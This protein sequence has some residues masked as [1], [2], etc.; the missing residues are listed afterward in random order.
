MSDM[1]P[2][3]TKPERTL[4]FIVPTLGDTAPQDEDTVQLMLFAAARLEQEIIEHP[5]RTVTAM[6]VTVE[7]QTSGWQDLALLFSRRALTHVTV[8]ELTEPGTP[9]LTIPCHKAAYDV[10]EFL[11]ARAFDEVHGLDRH[12]VLYYLTQGKRLGLYFLET[13]FAV[14]VV[15]GTIFRTE[16]EDALLDDVSALAEDLLERG[17]LERADAIYVHDT[18]AWRWYAGKIN[19]HSAVRIYDIAWP[20]G[21][22]APQ[23]SAPV[24]AGDIPAIVFYGTLG[25]DGGLPLFCDTIDRALPHL[26]GPVEIVCVGSPRPIGGSDAVSYIRLRSGAWRVP[27]RIERGLSVAEEVVRIA[28]QPAVVVCDT[29]RREGL[30]PRLIIDAG[31]PVLHITRLPGDEYPRIDCTYPALP[32]RI[33]AKLVEMLTTTR[34][35]EAQSSPRVMDLWRRHRPPLPDL[36]DLEPAQRLETDSDA[37]PKVSVIVTH[38]SRPQKLRTALRSLTQQTYRNFEVIVVDDGSPD[39]EVQAELQRIKEE[40]HAFG[41]RL[42]TQDNRYLGAARNCG[43]TYATGDY[44]LFMD[45]D[46]VAKPHEISTFVAVARRAQAGIVTA[47]CD[48]FD[49]DAELDRT[50]PP[51]RFTPFGSD[52]VLGIFTNCYGDANALYARS[53][54]DKLGGFTEDYGMTHEDW[55]LFCRASLEGVTM[56]C[57][58]EPLFWYRIDS[59]GMFRGQR[60]RLHKSANLRRHIRPFLAKLPYPQARLVQLAQ[61]LTAE[62]PI[63]TCG[64]ATRQVIPRRVHDQRRLPYARIAIIMRTKDRPLLLRRAIRSV[65]D[66]TFQDWL[67]VIVNDGGSQESVERIL[68]EVDTELGGRAL[69][70]HHVT[71][72]GMQTASNAGIV[73]CDSDFIV[74]HDDDDSWSPSFLARTVDY[75]DERGWN[76]ATG[77]V[78]TWSWLIVEALDDE[79]HWKQQNRSI[80]DDTLRTVSMVDLAVEN[81]F[82]PISFLFRRAAL[83]AVGP[84]REEHTVLGDWDFHLRVLERFDIGVIPEPLANYHHRSQATSGVYGNSVHTQTD[85]H[86][87]ARIALINSALRDG[88]AG[89]ANRSHLLAMGEL[90]RLVKNEQARALWLIQ[91]DIGRLERRVEHL[92][93]ALQK[94]SPKTRR[95]LASNGDFRRW[96]GP[97]AVHLGPDG[98]YAFMQVCP[99]FL[100]TYNG[101][102][103][104]YRVEQ[105]TWQNDAGPL[106]PGKTYL[107]MENDG[108]TRGGSWFM[109]ECRIPSVLALSGLPIF[110]S[111][112][113]RLKGNRD[114]MAIGGRYHLRDGQEVR[115]PDQ[116]VFIG[117]E[118]QRWAC[119]VEC[120]RVEDAEV[121]ASSEARILVKLPHDRAFEFDLTNVQ[122]EAGPMPT[123]FEYNA[124]AGVLSRAL[125]Q[126]WRGAASLFRTA[127]HAA[128]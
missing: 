26:E 99:G 39:P 9:T 82:P 17:S 46:N 104:S 81:R 88:Q 117:A 51:I 68:D 72:L 38:F 35:H 113:S 84:F 45:D 67:L 77:G 86:R 6:I 85:V 53:V 123:E 34:R 63:T 118:F 114:W 55:E 50:S 16:C 71:S 95:N 48:G 59:A 33:A 106:P 52:P 15:G 54:F 127:R 78:I 108:H 36:S 10:F 119:R 97:G 116:T 122:I 28:A 30:R 80:Y 27:V 102:E 20:T 37:P 107:H 75:M 92:T 47:F 42:V 91:S 44:L 110:I 11:K 112:M 40:I 57:V 98:K 115:W 66:Q 62:L 103:A 41:W 121:N 5:D 8:E 105:R 12:G 76:A 7:R 94:R 79:G 25:A 14:H 4:A 74:I 93:A 128:S 124:G 65:L 101:R 22:S 58:P 60:T 83:D 126:C 96:P 56:V 89:T 64:N 18:R 3:R 49:T 19:A 70:V 111:A 69:V 23:G 2:E 120:P 31:L 125:A 90:H 21:K 61:G 13:A 32:E 109:L 73:S 87:A 100:I 24:P 1:P 43:A 29:V